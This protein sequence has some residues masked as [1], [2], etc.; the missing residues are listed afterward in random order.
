[1]MKETYRIV[2]TKQ[3]NKLLFAYLKGNK[4]VEFHIFS[5]K[6]E[7][8]GSIYLGRVQQA[9]S[10]INASF[11]DFAENAR[12][13]L[14]R[15]DLK[16]GDLIPV[17]LV[18]ERTKT[19]DAVL[20]DELSLAGVYS[21]IHTKDT[22]LSVSSKLCAQEKKQLVKALRELAGEVPYGIIVRTNAVHADMEELKEEI[23]QLS[24][25]LSAV[26]K[27]AGTRTPASVLYRA[28]AEWMRAVTDIRLDALSEIVTDEKE[29]YESLKEHLTDTYGAAYFSAVSLRFYEDPMLSLKSC[30]ASKAGLR[31]RCRKR[32]GSNRADF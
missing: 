12:G 21:V 17:Q 18:K 20:S 1:M 11:I 32:C 27:Y 26:L 19:K 16:Q 6:K 25:R 2:L 3:Q 14:P 10:N 4:P 31:R 30:T 5:D 29:I 8:L 22:K 24:E 9:V 28:P 23:R 7:Q 13:F 15:A